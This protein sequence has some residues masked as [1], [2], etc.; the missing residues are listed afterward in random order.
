MHKD[1]ELKIV[2]KHKNKTNINNKNMTLVE[3][4]RFEM[5]EKPDAKYIT[6]G[7]DFYIS[8]YQVTFAEYDEFC[9]EEGNE[10]PYDEGW[11]REYRPVIHVSWY[12]AIEYCNWKSRKENGLEEVYT[13]DK[14]IKDL[15][16]E[17]E[18]DD[19]KWTITCNFDKKGYRLPTEAEWEFA[20]RG[21]NKSKEHYKYSGS[22]E[23]EEVAWYVNNSELIARSVGI[24]LPNELGIY[25]MSGNV[26]EW[27]WDWFSDNY[28]NSYEPKG[29]KTNSCRVLRGGSWS[30][31]ALD[32]GVADRNYYTPSFSSYTIGFRVS[33]TC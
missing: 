28:P 7:Y 22:N 13:I 31:R 29:S 2:S 9:K 4:G 19:K 32:C 18:D 8:K 20:A 30:N 14:S 12:D 24:R 10:K 6:I 27:C 11:G 17:D 5:G 3:A 23:I 33:K 16:I 25:D 21:G 26:D 1:K 15:N